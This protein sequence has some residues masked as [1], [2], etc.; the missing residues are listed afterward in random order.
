MPALTP[1]IANSL[2]GEFF[3]GG[4]S[5]AGV[6]HTYSRDETIAFFKAN[7]EAMQSEVRNMTPEQIAYRLPGAPDGPDASGD[8]EHFDTAE[9]VT[10]MAVGTVFHWGN[11]CR[12]LGQPR[13]AMP[14]PPE[15]TAATGRRKDGMGAG[16]WRGLSGPALAGYLT[17]SISGFVEF[18]ESL[19][20]EA[21]DT[22]TSS[23]GPFRDLSPRDWIFLASI[24]SGVHLGQMRHMKAQPDYPKAG[25]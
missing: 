17:S 6:S 16:G 11:A 21:L 25:A 18:A 5:I 22:G 20:D 9:I 2:A 23:F 7:I 12:A 10:H 13:P 15:G 8:E 4:G 3:G 19:P 14:R 24:H 1:E